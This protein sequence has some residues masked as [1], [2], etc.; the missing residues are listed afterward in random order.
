MELQGTVDEIYYEEDDVV[1]LKAPAPSQTLQDTQLEPA[2]SPDSEAEAFIFEHH[3]NFKRIR[4]QDRKISNE[5]KPRL[6][7][8]EAGRV[9][10]KIILRQLRQVDENFVSVAP[11]DGDLVSW[12]PSSHNCSISCNLCVVE[13]W[14][15][16]KPAW[17]S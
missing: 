12:N 8:G 5:V 6:K 10:E 16:L 4:E 13:A 15:Q 1:V 3:V 7:G 17:V 14:K 11:V 2:V 9:A